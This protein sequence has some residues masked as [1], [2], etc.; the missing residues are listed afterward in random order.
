MNGRVLCNG[1]NKVAVENQHKCNGRPS[2][3]M[4]SACQSECN[5]TPNKTGRLQCAGIIKTRPFTG[6]EAMV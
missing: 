1:K 3:T 5:M 6:N 4:L 2:P